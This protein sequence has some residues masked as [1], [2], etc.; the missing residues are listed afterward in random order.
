MP[1][2]T[3]TRVFRTALGDLTTRS[4][5]MSTLAVGDRFVGPDQK[6]VYTVTADCASHP[7]G[8]LFVRDL[9][10][11]DEQAV[12]LEDGDGDPRIGFFNYPTTTLLHRVV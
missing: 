6:T 1:S 11:T 5:P 10:M 3:T 4:V 12:S 9:T 2:D 7:H 8:W